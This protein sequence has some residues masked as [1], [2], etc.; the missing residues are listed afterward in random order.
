SNSATPEEVSDMFRIAR[1]AAGILVGA[2]ALSLPF[3]RSH[4]LNTGQVSVIVQLKGDP[5]AVYRAKTQ[6]NGGTV[7]DQQLQDYR[8]QLKASQDQFIAH[9]QAAGVNLKVQSVTI[10]DFSGQPAATVEYRYTLVYNGL[11]V[12]VPK[13]SISTLASLPEVK[14]VHTNY[15]LHLS[16]DSAVPY[17]DAP[18]LY[19]KNPNDLTPFASYP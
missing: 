10:P 11:G 19:G 9:A 13:A 14:A 18:A 15:A 5:G 6:K 17:V 7:S 16:L 3:I 8:D 4:A 12:T 1:Y 2:L